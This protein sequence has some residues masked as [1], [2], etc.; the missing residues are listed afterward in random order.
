VREVNVLQIAANA[1]SQFRAIDPTVLRTL[2]NIMASTGEDRCAV[3]ADGSALLQLRLADSCDANRASAACALD[4]NFGSKHRFSFTFNK[5]YQDRNPDQLNTGDQRF[6]DAPNFTH[7]VARRPSRSLTLRST[8]N[9]SM[10]NEFRVGITAGESILF[11]QPDSGGP[12][13]FAD[14]DNYA[15]TLG[16]STNW[17]T[18]N[19]LSGRSAW[20]YSFDDS[21]NW[22]K[23]QH[24]LT[25]GGQIY[26]GRF[27]ND[28]QQQVPG[29]TFGMNQAD[30][31]FNIFSNSAS[32][33]V[34]D[35]SNGQL[36]NAPRAV[37]PADWPGG[38]RDWPGG[39]G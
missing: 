22:Q 38:K 13:T 25:I 23:S 14:Q 35:A 20:Q 27:W 28:A 11:G 21:L 6:P 9:T 16:L 24:T 12:P 1:N 15:L 8:L 4:Y 32:G 5:L 37:R 19:N 3:G 33:T 31:D 26:L 2:N 17:H 36:G 18:T 39:A 29:I 7:T 34:P 10:V 30:P